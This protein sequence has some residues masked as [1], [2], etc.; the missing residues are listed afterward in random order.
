MI[1]AF[2]MHKP[3]RDCH[4]TKEMDDEV[5][6][7]RLP[8]QEQARAPERAPERDTLGNSVGVVLQLSVAPFP[9]Q[10]EVRIRV[11]HLGKYE[12]NRNKH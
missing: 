11:K 8:G 4:Q 5:D 3:A 2:Q 12:I 7:S 9:T 1:I 10:V 6:L